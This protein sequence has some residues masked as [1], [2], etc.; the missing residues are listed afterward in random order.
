[1]GKKRKKKPAWKKYIPSWWGVSDLK[2]VRGIVYRRISPS[3]KSYIGI[4]IHE[5]S[6]Q[7]KWFNSSVP[8]T[9]VGSK[10]DRAR[11]KYGAEN[12]QYT[13]IT[14]IACPNKKERVKELISFLKERE[15]FWIKHFDSFNNGYNSTPGGDFISTN[16]DTTEYLVFDIKGNL[17][18]DDF[19][20]TAIAQLTG[21]SKGTISRASKSE[22]PVIDRKYFIFEKETF[23][24]ERLFS[25]LQKFRNTYNKDREVVQLNIDG[26]LVKEFINARE[27]ATDI[28]KNPNASGQIIMLCQGTLKSAKTLGGYLW[29]F[30]D[31]YNIDKIDKY[32]VARAGTHRPV[33]QLSIEGGL[34]KVWETATA[35]AE[36]FGNKSSGHISQICKGR[37]GPNG[38]RRDLYKGYRWMFKE[39]YEE[40]ISHGEELPPLHNG[41]HKSVVQMD[42][43]DN[44]INRFESL[45]VAEKETKCDSSCISKCCRGELNYFKGFKWMYTI[46]YIS[47]YGNFPN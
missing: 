31:D 43:N 7:R 39:E 16:K 21:Y 38:K 17:V 28:L 10:I 1:M 3:G 29:K 35:A 11:D 2:T 47:K 25:T 41:H 27:A 40:M 19:G 6:R 14:R 20:R 32:R 37:V 8:Y 44:Y 15:V 24:E 33:V 5:D 12:F 23:T 26:T 30:K 34:I 22:L 46:D 9:K 13:V 42:M 36:S 18:F 4:T 45:K